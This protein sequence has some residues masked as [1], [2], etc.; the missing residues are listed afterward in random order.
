[1]PTRRTL[2]FIAIPVVVVGLFAWEFVPATAIIHTRQR[3]VALTVKSARS[4]KSVNCRVV[5]DRKRAKEFLSNF[6]LDVQPVRWS[7]TAFPY[8]G[9]PLKLKI[10]YGVARSPILGREID[11]TRY[12]VIVLAVNFQDGSLATRLIEMS[13]I[14]TSTNSLEI[15]IP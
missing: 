10:P 5:V 8:D 2:L 7:V 15:E 11:K 1:M 13:T 9:S 12:R 14:P 3:P 4:I 6:K